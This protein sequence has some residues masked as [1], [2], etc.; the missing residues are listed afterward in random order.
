LECLNKSIVV[1]GGR[2]YQSARPTS[3][4]LLHWK[5]GMD[6]ECRDAISRNQF[7]TRSFMTNNFLI[8]KSILQKLPFNEHLK[9]YGHEDTLLGIQL[10]LSGIEVY[11]IDNPLR[12]IGLEENEVFLNKTRD[13]IQN[14]LT[15]SSMGYDKS[16]L[17]VHVTLLKA[18]S[19]LKKIR[20]LILVGRLFFLFQPVLLALIRSKNPSLLAFDIY[21]LGF[22]CSIRQ[23]ITKKHQSI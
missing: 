23:E 7:P 14:L 10:F 19:K 21:K 20:L 17:N 18:Y 2:S 5:Y 22:L 1:C 6:R 11:H 15:I 13:G 16:L 3:K 8:P 4:Y 9:G 12:H